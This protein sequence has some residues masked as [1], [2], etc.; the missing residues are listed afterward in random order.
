MKE[1]W[2]V[3]EWDNYYPSGGIDNIALITF[4]YKEAKDMYETWSTS[5]KQGYKDSSTNLW[6]VSRTDNCEI[7][8]SNEL[9]WSESK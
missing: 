9:P 8:S 3:C 2:I 5:P 7:Y 1:F 4:D 6:V